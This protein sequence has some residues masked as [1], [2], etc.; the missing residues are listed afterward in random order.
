MGLMQKRM[1]NLQPPW[2]RRAVRIAEILARGTKLTE[3]V[4]HDHV[5][6]RG[7]LV[8]VHHVISSMEEAAELQH[9]LGLL[10]HYLNGKGDAP[11]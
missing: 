8:S 7:D 6:R 1:L 9:E 11:I 4:L 10:R 5:D 3:I 2:L